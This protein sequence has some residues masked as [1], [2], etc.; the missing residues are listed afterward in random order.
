MDK[1][2]RFEPI[3]DFRSRWKLLRNFYWQNI[4]TF[5]LKNI[6]KSVHR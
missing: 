1:Y 2:Y 3:E 4:F 5:F 6:H